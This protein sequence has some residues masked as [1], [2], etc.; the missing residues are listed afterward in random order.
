[1]ACVFNPKNLISQIIPLSKDVVRVTY[2]SVNEYIKENDASNI[3]VSLYTTS[4][5]RLK[6]ITYLQMI[7]SVPGTS[8]LYADT[9]SVRF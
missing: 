4:I 5:A 2:R 6:L 9:D 7:E 3:V 8:I 1:M